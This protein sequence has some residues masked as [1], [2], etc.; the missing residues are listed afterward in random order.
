MLYYWNI[1]TNPKIYILKIKYPVR[2]IWNWWNRTNRNIQMFWKLYQRLRLN[3]V[4]YRRCIEQM[5]VKHEPTSICNMLQYFDKQHS[6]E[7][8]DWIFTYKYKCI[9][10]YE[11]ALGFIIWALVLYNTIYCQFITAKHIWSTIVFVVVICLK[12]WTKW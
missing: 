6:S 5:I 12:S 8:Q 9:Y 11:I 10:T 2:E 3:Q 4:I 7:T 1:G